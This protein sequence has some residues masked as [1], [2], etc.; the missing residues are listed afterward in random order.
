LGPRTD[1]APGPADPGPAS[2][3]SGRRHIPAPLLA[4]LVV[5]AILSP[6]LAGYEP[7]GGDADRF[8]RPV[9]AELA[10]ALR[11]G[12]PPFWSDAYGLGAPLVAE[13]QC[14]AFYP[15]NHILYRLFDVATAYRLAM[16][17][18]HVGMAAAMAWYAGRLGLGPPGAALAGVVLP[19]CGYSAIHASHEVHYQ[20]IAWTPLAL[21][22]AEATLAGGGLAAAAGLALVLGVQWTVGQFQFAVWTGALVLVTA[23]WR[24]LVDR[25]GWRRGTLAAL[26]VGLGMALAA[27]QLVPTAAL[28]R[29][30]ERG[31]E[32]RAAQDRLYFS[33]PPSHLA[34]PAAPRLFRAAG[35]GPNTAYWHGQ[36]TS[37]YEAAFYAGTI[38]LLL[39]PLGLLARSRPRALWVALGALGLT[40]ATMPRWWPEGYLLVL[41]LPGIGMFRAPARFTLLS[42]IA[43]AILGG[44]GLDRLRDRGT[45]RVG[46]GLLL[47][48][49]LGVAML[50]AAW[51]WAAHGGGRGLFRVDP[52]RAYLLPAALVWGGSLVAILAVRAGLSPCLLVALTALELGWLYVTG[53]IVWGPAVRLP[54]DS[55]VLSRLAETPGVARVAGAMENL[56][57]RVGLATATPYLGFPLWGA[58][59]ALQAIAANPDSLADPA[60]RGWLRSRGVTH[61]V[62]YAREGAT[63][64]AAPEG[65]TVLWE[66][67]DPAL[68]RVVN[69][70]DGGTGPLRWRILGLGTPGPPARVAT[71]VQVAADD[72]AM[73]RDLVLGTAPPG[74]AWI[75]AADR[76][77]ELQGPMARV[78][79]LERWDG[80]AGLISHD[81]PCLLVANRAADPGW[82]AVVGGRT[83]ST[84]AADGG[85]LAVPLAGS[86]RTEVRL[87]Y[88]PPG[89]R[90]ARG[91]S[92]ATLA[93]VATG[94]GV[95][96]WRRRPRPTGPR[97]PGPG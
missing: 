53:P 18:H 44:A 71:R 87:V 64:G 88:T 41:K 47:G 63:F 37:G 58:N 62:H 14:G 55:P 22:L 16:W 6:L 75:A 66:G 83:I 15:V 95:G 81:G 96:P 48:A 31:G 35:G 26:A 21:G 70:P 27:V 90:F 38:P 68:D 9:K 28:V 17:A 12:T 76:M 57:V 25:Q 3:P 85:L 33:Y 92:L 39:L 72:R 93:V 94:L 29:Q 51:W 5:G 7:V 59:R 32:A 77:P 36:Q 54:A 49:L 97:D 74:T 4:A 79:T 91:L 40:L 23:C 19:L 86:G 56:P 42:T 65:V 45:R 2:R 73:L 11:A 20:V 89:W 1:S 24:V 67:P 69:R 46:I 13:S 61:A 10:S 78:A 30:T 8:N 84:T 80:R 60:A 50:G 43:V 52:V 34:E 82:R